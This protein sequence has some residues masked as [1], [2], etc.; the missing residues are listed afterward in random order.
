[1]GRE[2]KT[3]ILSTTQIMGVER[4][5]CEVDDAVPHHNNKRPSPQDCR[6][7][8]QTTKLDTIHIPT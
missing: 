2:K 4:Q 5:D 3:L 6:F 1:M 8:P 7:C